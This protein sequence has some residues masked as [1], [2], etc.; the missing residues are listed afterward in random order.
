MY[1]IIMSSK[2]AVKEREKERWMTLENNEGK[3]WVTQSL[4]T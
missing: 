2:N 3:A 4:S 1:D